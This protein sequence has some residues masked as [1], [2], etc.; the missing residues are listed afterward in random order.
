MSLCGT[1]AFS[2]F[3]QLETISGAENTSGEQDCGN[4]TPVDVAVRNGEAYTYYEIKTGLSAQSCIRQAIGQLMEYSYWPGAQAAEKLV[5]VGEPPLDEPAKAYL[6]KLRERFSLPLY[7][8]QFD[9]QT[10]A[11]IG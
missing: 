1:R 10:G 11:L 8:Q 7:Y 6:E 5:I 9:L 2:L 3:A 4:G